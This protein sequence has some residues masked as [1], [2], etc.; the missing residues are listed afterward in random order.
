VKSEFGRGYATCLIQFAFHR[1]RLAESIETYARMRA[2]YADSFTERY[3]VEIWANGA[4]DHLYDLIRPRRGLPV[5][6]WRAARAL[7]DRVLDIGHG[8]R[9]TSASD[10][11]EAYR[12]LDETDR[13]LALTGATT[14]DDALAWDR[15]HGLAPQRGQWFCSENL[16][17]AENL[18]KF[19]RM[20]TPVSDD[21]EGAG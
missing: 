19:T 6:A 5:A 4:S 11:A 8:Y 17:R 18:E 15:E 13:L 3:A 7:A 2:K 20:T 21:T 9:P 1:A 16:S 12:L 14:L 10:P